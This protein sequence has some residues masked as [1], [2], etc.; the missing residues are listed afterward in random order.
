[1]FSTRAVLREYQFLAETHPVHKPLNNGSFGR[2]R[3]QRGL[4]EPG[5]S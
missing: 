1:M 2:K 5:N 4:S 3:S